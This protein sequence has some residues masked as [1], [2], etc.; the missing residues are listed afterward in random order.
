[1]AKR[2]LEVGNFSGQ[3]SRGSN[4]KPIRELPSLAAEDEL[5]PGET[6]EN[7]LAEFDY[8]GKETREP[9]DENGETLAGWDRER[10]IKSKLIDHLSDVVNDEEDEEG[11]TAFSAAVSKMTPDQAHDYA[12]VTGAR[13]E[14]DVK[15][16][17][18]MWE[19][20]SQEER[21]VAASASPTALLARSRGP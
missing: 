10:A 13:I 2:L 3:Q 12:L 18:Q 9:K 21:L 17:G 14:E 4:K 8:P 11:M 15:W 6:L 7:T 20:I 1:M 5:L 19:R 16:K